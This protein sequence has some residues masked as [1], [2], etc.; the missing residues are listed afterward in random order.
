ML[1]I[2][3]SP[4]GHLYII[5]GEMFIQVLCPFFNAVILLFGFEL[6][7]FFIH[8]AINSLSDM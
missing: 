8:L 1:N 5:F 6:Q 4:V 3:L 7:E 2:F